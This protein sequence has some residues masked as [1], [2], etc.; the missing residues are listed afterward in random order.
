MGE[1]P[2]LLDLKQTLTALSL[3]INTTNTKHFHWNFVN[4]RYSETWL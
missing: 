1:F 2:T 3:N 4:L